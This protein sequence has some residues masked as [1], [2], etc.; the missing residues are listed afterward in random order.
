[1]PDWIPSIGTAGDLAPR[2]GTIGSDNGAELC[3]QISI[4]PAARF[5]V[6]PDDEITSELSINSLVGVTFTRPVC[7][8][9]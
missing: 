4:A 1:M 6:G 9:G 5:K 3:C 8:E 7:F 2:F